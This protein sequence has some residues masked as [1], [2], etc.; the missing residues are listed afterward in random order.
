MAAAGTALIKPAGL[1]VI[2]KFS[3]VLTGY[4]GSS[5]K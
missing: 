5:V 1:P 2:T 4:A 3:G